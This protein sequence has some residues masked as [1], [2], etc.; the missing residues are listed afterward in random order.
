[1][2]EKRGREELRMIGFFKFSY[3]MEDGII[4]WDGGK[5]G[6]GVFWGGDWVGLRV[7]LWR[8]WVWGVYVESFDFLRM[9]LLEDF[10]VD[11]FY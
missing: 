9:V 6:E 8:Y 10:F 11:Y 3:G 4:Y 7:L 1:M 5:L 2:W